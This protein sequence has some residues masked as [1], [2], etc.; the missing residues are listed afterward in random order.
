MIV[1]FRPIKVRPPSWKAADAPRPRSPF[2]STYSATEELL[3]K[4][5]RHLGATSAFLQVE[6]RDPI[7]GVRQDGQ[8]HGGHSMRFE[9]SP[10]GLVE[11]LVEP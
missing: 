11:V 1:T 5:L 6:L 7:R 4:E 9:V 10:D 2:S 3:Q 8:P